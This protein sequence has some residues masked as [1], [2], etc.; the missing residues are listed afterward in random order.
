MS[1]TII[2][3]GPSYEGKLTVDDVWPGLFVM[4]LNGNWI[5]NYQLQGYVIDVIEDY[6]IVKPTDIGWQL[7]HHVDDDGFL[8][9]G[10][11]EIMILRK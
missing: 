10:L 1:K 3:Y 9:L 4:A 2:K 5:Y 8:L 11:H 7:D 6:V